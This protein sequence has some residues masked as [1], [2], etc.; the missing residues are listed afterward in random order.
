MTAGKVKSMMN[1]GRSLRC[2]QVAQPKNRSVGIGSPAMQ[3]QDILLGSIAARA[4]PRLEASAWMLQASQVKIHPGCD[5]NKEYT[6]QSH[7]HTLPADANT[8]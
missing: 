5:H 1:H 8:G 6:A 3:A 4:A 7:T 2:F